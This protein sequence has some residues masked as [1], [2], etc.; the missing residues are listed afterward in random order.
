MPTQAS[1]ARSLL[2]FVLTLATL[3]A[4]SS[5]AFF[6]PGELR[7]DLAT[8]EKAI[9]DTHPDIAHSV[10][11][12]DLARS[13][14]DIDHKL[15]TPMDRDETWRLLATLNPLLA[16]GHTFVGFADWRA[17]TRAHI[18]AG[19]VL[20]PFE[21]VV[22]TD[23]AVFIRSRLGGSDSDLAGSRIEAI[24]GVDA[25]T[26][27]AELL[28]RV[29]GDT[30]AFRREVLSRRW[31]FY[32]WKICGARERFELTLAGSK[33][34]PLQIPGSRATPAFIADE[35]QFE[36]EFRLE[37]LPDQAALLTIGTFAWPDEKQF[38]AF[39]REAFSKIRGTGVRT[40]V[41]DV[42]A[43]GGGDDAMW[44]K[45]IMPYIATSKYRW[46][47]TYRKRVIEAY[48]DEGETTGEVVSGEL[49]RWIEPDASNPLKFSG[50]TFVLVGP[51]TY[52]S[53]IL[54]SNVV[55]DFGFG[56][57][58]GT[59]GSVRADQS[60]GV[61]KVLLPRTGL[62]VYVPRFILRRPSGLAEPALVEPDLVI[63]ENPFRPRA[64]IE[65]LLREIEDESRGPATGADR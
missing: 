31:W 5:E 47:S 18:A 13:L 41:I 30:P 29:H 11:D 39:T 64:A 6:P 52:S 46:G 26:I 33:S 1:V 51:G 25:R 42:R 56:T 61:Q 8:L 38:L 9:Y 54:F 49:D 59:G 43:N 58:A 35:E 4:D 63:R 53:A 24:D 7:E 27:S 32:F 34:Q 36:R 14:R 65:L 55:Q 21:V 48:R 60:G 57:V 45:G 62:A 20:F 23:N 3:P 22:A 44:I 2:I 37:L 16:D 50:R 10:V 15:V 12:A 17:D 28:A 40:L 19:G